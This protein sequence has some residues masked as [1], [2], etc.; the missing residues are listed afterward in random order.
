VTLTAATIANHQQAIPWEAVKDL[1]YESGQ[2]AV[3]TTQPGLYSMRFKVEGE[4]VRGKALATT[5]RAQAPVLRAEM[6]RKE[7]FADK[8]LWSPRSY[9]Q[10][11]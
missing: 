1:T 8:P 3:R 7:K 10:V 11:E 5:I 9:G 6:E 2:L 4:S